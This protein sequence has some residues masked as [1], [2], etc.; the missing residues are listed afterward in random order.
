MRPLGCSDHKGGGPVDRMAHTAGSSSQLAA[1]RRLFRARAPGFP[2]LLQHLVKAGF[3][4]PLNLSN[5]PKIPCPS[6]H[7]SQELGLASK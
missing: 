6:V 5:F 3:Y 1:P 4:N 7:S 2:P